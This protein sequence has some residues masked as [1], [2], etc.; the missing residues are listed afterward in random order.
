MSHPTTMDP[1]DAKFIFWEYDIYPFTLGAVA[2]PRPNG[3]WYAPSYQGTFKP[4]A[5]YEVEIGKGILKELQY[6]AVSRHQHLKNAEE[7]YLARAKEI[8][9]FVERN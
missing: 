9:P 5:I 7:I 1:K 4:I 2:Y 3:M 6:E 8:A